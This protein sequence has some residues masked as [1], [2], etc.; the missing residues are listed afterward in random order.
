MIPKVTSCVLVLF[1][2]L[3]CTG[4]LNWPG[5][6]GDSRVEKLYGGSDGY[7]LIAIPALAQVRVY[8]VTVRPG[9]DSSAAIIGDAT[10]VDGPVQPG[11]ESLKQLSQILTSPDTYSWQSAKASK[12]QP[13]FA[14]RFTGVKTTIDVL[15]DFSNKLLVVYENGQRVGGEDFDSR[16]AKLRSLVNEWYP[17]ISVH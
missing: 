7:E 10:I 1:A 14:V 6:G 9:D 8:R 4:C 13:A 15:L 5:P 17:G 3:T 16:A 12:F 2:S 11:P